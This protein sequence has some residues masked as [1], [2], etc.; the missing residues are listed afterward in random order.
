LRAGLASLFDEARQAQIQ[1][2][3]GFTALAMAMEALRLED[4]ADVALEAQ[5]RSSRGISALESG[6]SQQQEKCLGIEHGSGVAY[7]PAPVPLAEAR[8]A[9]R[10]ETCARSRG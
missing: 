5:R 10:Q 1:S 4:G 7:G 8:Q 2:A 9:I 6:G 3:L